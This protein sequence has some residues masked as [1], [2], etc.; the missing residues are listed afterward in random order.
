M[1]AETTETA[2]AAHGLRERKK[3]ETRTA[4]RGA[5]VRLYL[6]HGPA[7]V[8]VHDI[9]EAA[10]VSPRTFFNY[11]DT[12]DDAVFDWDHRLTCQL[13]ELLAARPREEPPLEALRQTLR[14]AIPA[15]VADA[16]WH[17]RRR[18][19]SAYPELVPKLVH[20]NSNMAEALAEAV[21][22]R[23]GLPQEALYPRLVAGSALTAL[24]ASIRAWDPETSAE[25]LLA[26][27][28][29]GFVSLAAGLPEPE[30]DG[31]EGTGTGTGTGGQR[32]PS[33]SSRS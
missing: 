4:L 1:A 30:P 26:M 15:L 18:L 32:P 28:E 12:K 33:A 8:T 22:T 2:E 21:A 25:Q 6:E 19:L 17:E 24:R 31:D 3:L 16:G 5:A 7:A 23:T 11:F 29:E 27:L 14:T 20:S 10:G 13:V 9:C